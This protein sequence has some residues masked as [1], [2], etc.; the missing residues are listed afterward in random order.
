MAVDISVSFGHTAA[1]SDQETSGTN[2]PRRTYL[3]QLRFDHVSNQNQ[4]EDQEG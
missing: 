4:D 3:C 1:K 2:A